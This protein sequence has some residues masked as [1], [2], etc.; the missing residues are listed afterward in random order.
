MSCLHFRIQHLDMIRECMHFLQ[1]GSSSKFN[2]AEMTISFL[3]LQSIMPVRQIY[4]NFLKRPRSEIEEAVFTAFRNN[5]TV[6]FDLNLWC[7]LVDSDLSSRSFYFLVMLIWQHNF[8]WSSLFCS[9]VLVQ[10]SSRCVLHKHQEYS[11]W[12]FPACTA[13]R[14][15]IS[16]LAEYTF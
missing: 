15:L 5:S 8:I 11:W 9:I 1:S 6:N 12:C 16:E 13:L 2:K 7:R 4:L 14:L 10:F 3:S